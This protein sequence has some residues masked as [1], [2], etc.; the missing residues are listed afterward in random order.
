M[1]RRNKKSPILQTSDFTF[2][3]GISL[4]LALIIM[5]ILIAIGLGVSLI[6]VSQMKMM[7]GMG[8]SVV[9]FYAAD[10]GIEQTLY[11]V[12]VGGGW[13]GDIS[14]SIDGASYY[15]TSSASDTYQSKGSFANVKR[16]I[17]IY[18][19]PPAPPPPA[20]TLNCNAI[21]SGSCEDAGCIATG[22]GCVKSADWACT[23]SCPDMSSF[24]ASTSTNDCTVSDGRICIC[25]DYGEGVYNC[26]K[27]GGTCN[28]T[29]G[30]CY[31][32]CDS[33]WCDL[34]GDPSD[35]CESPC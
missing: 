20:F 6:I 25:K 35:G 34:N 17:E 16:A 19:P 3:K 27:G 24:H 23:P 2:Q 1:K 18:S 8:D 15:V 26:I 30:Q 29:S 32:Y 10:T 21:A 28:V 14:G 13:S 7:K 11:Q 12:R 22:R 31:Y 5:F 4:Y 9:A 33:G